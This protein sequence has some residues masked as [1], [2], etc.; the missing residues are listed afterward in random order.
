MCRRPQHRE[1]LASLTLIAIARSRNFIILVG[2]WMQ[3]LNDLSGARTQYF[4]VFLKFGCITFQFLCSK[5]AILCQFVDVRMCPLL[6][7]GCVI[8]DVWM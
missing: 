8:V 4:V 2:V 5:D 1:R 3:E 6:V 7:N